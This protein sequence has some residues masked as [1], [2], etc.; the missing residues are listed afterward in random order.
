MALMER[1]PR[2]REQLRWKRAIMLSLVALVLICSPLFAWSVSRPGGVAPVA[3][4]ARV[5]VQPGDTLWGIAREHGPARE[6]VRSIVYR[7]K[8][9]SRLDT[10]LIHPGDVLLVPQDGNRSG[11][12][13]KWTRRPS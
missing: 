12:R 4:V 10:S 11:G 1:R 7:I 6:D 8:Q 3:P 5:V 2:Q 13:G 9:A